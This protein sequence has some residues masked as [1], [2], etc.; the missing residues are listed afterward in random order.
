MTCSLRVTETP[1]LPMLLIA[2]SAVSISLALETAERVLV[3]AATPGYAHVEHSV[4]VSKSWIVPSMF[5]TSTSDETSAQFEDPNH[6]RCL[7]RVIESALGLEGSMNALPKCGMPFSE[8]GNLVTVTSVMSLNFLSP[9]LQQRRSVLWNACSICCPV[10]Q[11]KFT[12]AGVGPSIRHAQYYALGSKR[13]RQCQSLHFICDTEIRWRPVSC[14]AALE[15]L[16][17]KGRPPEKGFFELPRIIASSFRITADES[18]DMVMVDVADDE[19]LARP[20]TMIFVFS[21]TVAVVAARFPF[22]KLDVT[23]VKW[24]RH[25]KNVSWQV[26]CIAVLQTAWALGNDLQQGQVTWIINKGDVVLYPVCG[27]FIE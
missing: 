25:L 8:E 3:E 14:A 12:N 5:V 18:A 27:D 20:D 21:E 22:V 17:S 16:S 24:W 7:T 10:A 11:I 13:V 9:S 15:V 26:A 1:P 23:P 6:C 2:F 19:T 4:D